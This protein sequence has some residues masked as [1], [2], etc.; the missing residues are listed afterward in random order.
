MKNAQNL[1][2]IVWEEILES[3]DDLANSVTPLIQNHVAELIIR[4][5]G[6][7]DHKNDDE[8]LIRRQILVKHSVNLERLKHCIIYERVRQ[9]KLE[10]QLAGEKGAFVMMSPCL[11]Q[12]RRVW[13][14]S[15]DEVVIA[16][17]VMKLF[18]SLLFVVYFFN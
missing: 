9:T 12:I 18:Y 10:I 16:C 17:V 8:D 7:E 1:V 13:M 15:K 2:A 6:Y 4:A 14:S 5:E 3:E 11:E